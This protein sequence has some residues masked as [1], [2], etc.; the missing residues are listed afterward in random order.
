M[1]IDFTFFWVVR[2]RTASRRV[3]LKFFVIIDQAG[4]LIGLGGWRGFG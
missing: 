1:K 2:S 4:S 3:W